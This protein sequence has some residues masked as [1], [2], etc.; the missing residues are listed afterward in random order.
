MKT[1]VLILAL[2]IV[3]VFASCDNDNVDGLNRTLNGIQQGI[4]AMQEDIEKEKD[5]MARYKY[6]KDE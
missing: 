6:G 2:C 4:Q 3:L 5:A 1:T